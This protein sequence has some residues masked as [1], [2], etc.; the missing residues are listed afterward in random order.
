MLRFLLL[1]GG[2]RA[3]VQALFPVSF[4]LVL[5]KGSFGLAVVAAPGFTTIYGML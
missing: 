2:H 5:S 1:A 3:G 4:S